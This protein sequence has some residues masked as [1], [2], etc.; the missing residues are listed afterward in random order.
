MA[1]LITG[2]EGCQNAQKQTMMLIQPNTLFIYFGEACSLFIPTFYRDEHDLATVY[3]HCNV[4][5]DILKVYTGTFQNT[6]DIRAL[7]AFAHIIMQLH[8]Q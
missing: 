8:V 2:G 5:F 6:V 1:C 4:P 3:S 7:H